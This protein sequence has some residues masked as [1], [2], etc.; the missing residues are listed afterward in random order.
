MSALPLKTNSSFYDPT[1]S[2]VWIGVPG[3]R[4]DPG[5]SVPMFPND[6]IH[7]LEKALLERL[8]DSSEA[9][10]EG[11]LHAVRSAMHKVRMA[12][13]PGPRTSAATSTDSE[14]VQR[15]RSLPEPVREL[16]RRHYVFLE[17]EESICG[18]ANMTPKQFRK[19]RRE[20]VDYVLMRRAFP[21]APPATGEE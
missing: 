7:A 21:G 13:Q 8:R 10:P 14:A 16:L 4:I 1:R 6:L 17:A 11:P 3:V 12:V 19:L 18:S 5:H 15:I 2:A 9:R 20:A